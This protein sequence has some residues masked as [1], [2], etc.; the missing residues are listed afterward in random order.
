M[1]F[2]KH[3]FLRLF[4][5]SYNCH[6]SPLLMRLLKSEWVT[7]WYNIQLDPIQ[8]NLVLHTYSL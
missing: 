2:P 6:V 3:F 5:I 7:Q 4:H 1:I 8:K